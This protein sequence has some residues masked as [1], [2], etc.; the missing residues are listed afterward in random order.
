MEVSTMVMDTMTEEYSSGPVELLDRPRQAKR[1]WSPED[2]QRIVAETYESGASVSLV[3]RRH[4]LNTNMLFAWRRKARRAIAE[5]IEAPA[6][7]VAAHVVPVSGSDPSAPSAEAMGRMEIVL[8]DGARVIV[9]SDVDATAL[10]RVVKVL[11]RR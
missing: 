1:H 8:S 7:F 10:G 4:D 9:G 6:G 5:V 11:S 2:K 3:A